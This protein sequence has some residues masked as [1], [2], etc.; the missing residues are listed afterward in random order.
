[1]VYWRT[2]VRRLHWKRV[3]IHR[4]VNTTAAEKP[5]G[6]LAVSII[7]R[8]RSGRDSI[9]VEQAAYATGHLS[10]LICFSAKRWS[11]D[12]LAV[13]GWCTALVEL[14]PNDR[15][16]RYTEFGSFQPVSTSISRSPQTRGCPE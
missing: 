10:R 11:D 12:M 1:M 7:G 8:T 4:L 3:A 2:V 16:L 13:D 5:W 14:S 9:R 15:L 6:S